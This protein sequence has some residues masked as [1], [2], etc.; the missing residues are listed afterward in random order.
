MDMQQALNFL[1]QHQP[2]P[3]D[4]IASG[5]LFKNYY[6]AMIFFQENY[7]EE[8]VPLFLNSF[9]S[10]SGLGVY[11]LVEDVINKYP[12]EVVIPHLV[13]AIINGTDPIKAWCSQIAVNFPDERLIESLESLMTYDNDD[14]RW[15]AI[16]ALSEIKSERVFWLFKKLQIKEKDEYNKGMMIDYLEKHKPLGDGS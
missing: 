9:G 11:Q 3:D 15:A 7:N 10:F 6:E 13:N 1:K 5:D 16:S 4:E 12:A 2:M 8:C 14:I